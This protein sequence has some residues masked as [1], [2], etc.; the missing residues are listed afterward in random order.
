VLNATLC[1]KV[2]QLLLQV[3]GFLRSIP[4]FITNKTD[5]HVNAALI[6]YNIMFV[7]IMSKSKSTA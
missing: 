3:G 1:D 2:C 4:V 5:H 7:D 6:E